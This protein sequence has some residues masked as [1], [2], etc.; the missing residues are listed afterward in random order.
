LKIAYLSIVRCV[1]FLLALNVCAAA[2]VHK[3]GPDLYAY[4][5]ENDASANATFLVSD[6]GILVVDTGL[7]AQEGHKLLDEIH[8]I[9]QA[10][11]RWIVNTHYHP[12]HRGGNDVVGPDAAIISTAFTRAQI[13]SASRDNAVSETVGSNGL[14]LYL[15]GHEVR[16]YHPGPAHTR[17]DLVVYFPD[18]HAIATGD[19]FLNNSCSAMDDGDMENWI[20]A[21]DQILAL[22]VE[23]VVPGHFG[24]ATKNELQHFRNYLADLRDQV[25][26]MHNKGLSLEQVQKA[27]ALSAY[28]DLRQ[29][30]QYE[31]TFKD[32][33]A[34]Y[35]KQLEGWKPQRRQEH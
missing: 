20:A 31:A 16:I 15:G 32:N 22:P 23:H 30:P 19:L 34:A 24:L 5:S 11:V 29:F 18:E 35:Y 4:I 10:P 21:L 7:N 28:K 8:K 27:L 1:L 9:S 26:R 3:I 33:A 6:Q 2:S 12:D 17:G 14:V 13:A 25:K